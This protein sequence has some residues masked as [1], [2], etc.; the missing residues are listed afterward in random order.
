MES[1]ETNSWFYKDRPYQLIHFGGVGEKY[2]G[3]P[4]TPEGERT[5]ERTPEALEVV[6]KTGESGEDYPSS[7]E[8]KNS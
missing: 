8:R 1:H 3:L 5:A 2:D 6:A 7:K 4:S